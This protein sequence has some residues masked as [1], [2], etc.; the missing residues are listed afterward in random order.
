MFLT[1]R[2]SGD[3]QILPDQIPEYRFDEHG[4]VVGR[5]DDCHWRLLC[6]AKLISRRHAVVTVEDGRY[7]LYDA[8][9]NG[10]FVNDKSEP[11]G[12]GNRVELQ[13]GDRLR[14]GNFLVEV[15]LESAQADADANGASDNDIGAAAADTGASSRAVPRLDPLPEATPSV[16]HVP[17]HTVAPAAIADLGHP[18]D[19]FQP[20]TAVIPEDWDFSVE[21][22]PE[23][24]DRGASRE[25]A[26]HLEALEP[27]SRRAILEGLG[28]DRRELGEDDLG[29]EALAALAATLRI[30]LRGLFSL[31]AEYESAERIFS[32]DRPERT[33]ARTLRFSDMENAGGFLETLVREAQ[34]GDAAPMLDGLRADV[35]HMQGMHYGT[36]TTLWKS[37]SAVINVFSPAEVEAAARAAAPAG[38]VARALFRLRLLLFPGSGFWRFYNGWFDTRRNTANGTARAMFGKALE[39]FMANRNIE[40]ARSRTNNEGDQ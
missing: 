9:A 17:R 21:S 40:D 10:V 20:P 7:C 24:K 29:P 26:R 15:S 25:V 33:G 1:F 36:I 30:C 13:D 14:M 37:F 27:A 38:G 12:P 2:L 35:R 6:P 28:L 5:S 18:E 4:G 39:H 34:T 19:A 3:T 22:G 32:P 31:R 11:V 23:P 8:S 16:S